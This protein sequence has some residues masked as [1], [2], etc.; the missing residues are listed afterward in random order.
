MTSNDTEDFVIPTNK[1]IEKNIAQYETI[2]RNYVNNPEN[3][4]NNEEL[5]GQCLKATSSHYKR[6]IG[7]SSREELLT[8]IANADAKFRLAKT[9]N[10]QFSV[11]STQESNTLSHVASTQFYKSCK[12][13]YTG[14]CN[15]IFGD[16]LDLPARYESD[17]NSEDYDYAEGQ[18]IA[19]EQTEYFRSVYD[20]DSWS[21]II[22]DSMYW[23][24]KNAHE[25]IS[26][27][28]RYETDTK[29]ER[30]PGYFTKDGKPIEVY[31]EN[32]AAI[33][34]ETKKPYTGQ[35]Y[36][37]NGYQVEKIF[38]ENGRPL[39]YVF[40]DKT[41]VVR[42]N[43]VLLRYRMEDCYFDLDIKDDGSDP[44]LDYMQKQTCVIVHT[45]KTL[46]Q[47]LKGARDGLYENIDK[48]S[49]AHLANDSNV[50]D[51][52][53]IKQERDENADQETDKQETGLFDS[54]H[55]FLKAPIDKEK[56]EWSDSEI[57]EWTEIE[58]IGK[59]S[60]SMPINLKKGEKAQS[61][62]CILLRKNI[63]H[64]KRNPFKLI[65]SHPDERGGVHMGNYTLLEC[66]IE[67][68][69][70][71]INQHID[72]KTLRIKSPWIGKKDSILNKNE[73]V[74]KNGNQVV[75]INGDVDRSLKKIDIP[76]T[77]QTTLPLLQMLKEDANETVG[78]TD[79]IQG[80]YAGS[81][82][83]G[84][85]VVN[86]RAQALQP[87]IESARYIANQYFNFILRDTS[88]LCRQFS[89]PSKTIKNGNYTIRPAELYGSL[90]TKVVAVDQFNADMTAKNSLTAFIQAGGFE[91]AQ[92]YMGQSGGL[93]F[94]RMYA[95]VN[96]MPD[97]LSI[98]PEARKMVEAENQAYADIAVILEDPERASND[99]DLLPKEGEA[100]DV[101][102]KILESA[103]E[104]AKAVMPMAEEDQ[105]ER[106]KM[107]IQVFDLYILIHNQLKTQESQGSG[108]GALS[109]GGQ[110]Q[111]SAEAALPTLEGE[112]FGDE[113]AGQQ[114]QVA[115]EG[116]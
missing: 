78:T 70:T 55:V 84:T 44:Y 67:E 58:F 69:T 79:V 27:Q 88:D 41:R 25:L 87:A 96:K 53:D 54:Y 115:P 17:E 16:N 61:P 60:D 10:K 45:Q 91:K 48:I 43:P 97:Y 26:V 37:R 113:L 52:V 33:A 110:Q 93:N 32:G 34:S 71:T 64:H 98:F 62:V 99:P 38:D 5:A 20:N 92:P 3:M 15:I 105:A 42:E 4:C 112:A 90:K 74:F 57:P 14:L 49:S 29:T 116:V 47:L 21:S 75:W 83:T 31:P 108:V 9:Q 28:W 18:R 111:P 40:I 101:H 72:N 36:D 104:K 2:Q 39:S 1:G 30:V 81:R 85:E 12:L 106:L 35:G 107:S 100:H 51:A 77:T 63:Y 89:N 94:W 59:I 86:V 109:A 13:I 11:G 103:R 50:V 82:T 76:D 66:N 102:I 7:Q 114:G 23:L 95:K 8:Y 24:V 80:Q 19:T 6:F 46:E 56:K 73:L 65:F 22:K 68:Q